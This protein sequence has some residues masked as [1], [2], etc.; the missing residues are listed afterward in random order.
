MNGI[1]ALES[2][3]NFTNTHTVISTIKHI[4]NWTD[5]EIEMIFEIGKKNSQVRYILGDL[6]VK[7]F[8]KRLL[9]LP[10]CNKETDNAKEIIELI[11]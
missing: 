2:S 7:N 4:N 10:T 1:L 9:E 11:S 3:L 5:K 6:D 8:Y